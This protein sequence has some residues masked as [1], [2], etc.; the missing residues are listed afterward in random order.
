MR[1]DAAAR[2]DA[3]GLGSPGADPYAGVVSIRH[4]VPLLE[5]DVAQ[6][7]PVDRASNPFGAALVRR[8]VLRDGHGRG[9]I[10][11][12]RL[13]ADAEGYYSNVRWGDDQARTILGTNELKFHFKLSGNNTVEFS[14]GESANVSTGQMSVLLQPHGMRKLDCVPK[15]APEHSLTII[16][17]PTLLTAAL[18]LDP[19]SLPEPLRSFAM[20]R[21]QGYWLE[22]LPLTVAAKKTLED[23]LHSPH[24][25]RFSHIHATA[26]ALD[27]ICLFLDALVGNEQQ[28][29][30]RLSARDQRAL[31]GIRS[32]LAEHYMAPPTLP[33]LA[34]MA[35]MN[36][37]KLTQGFRELFG[38]TVLDYCLRMRMS[39]AR[40]LLL[41]GEA[42][43]RVAAA[44]GYE[45]HS[46]F[47]Q[48]FKAY[49]GFAPTE[50][51]RRESP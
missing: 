33:E 19:D 17:R 18:G 40:H 3:R 9:S 46:S 25:G 14:N 51:P 24:A 42:V 47:S 28:P 21:E 15:T 8:Q 23:M 1:D 30:T 4:A 36:R 45:H 43:G 49:F 27:L 2:D 50:R 32:Y 10:D 20:Q 38:E 26:R 7:V 6:V 16:C 41:E 11:L 37:T 44:V 5:E 39:R 12:L 22:T 48:A 31:D 13:G 29:R 34:R 35:G